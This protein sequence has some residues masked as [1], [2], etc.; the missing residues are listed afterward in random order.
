MREAI[1]GRPC[2]PPSRPTEKRNHFSSANGVCAGG[3]Q[4]SCARSSRDCGP[5][6]AMLCRSSVDSLTQT[7]QPEAL[8]LLAQPDAVVLGAADEAEV[9][10]RR[11][12]RRCRRR[13]SR[14]SRCTS[15]CR[16]P[17]RRRA[18]GCRASSSPA[19]AP[20]R[21]G[22]GSRTS[23]AARGPSPPRCSRQAQYSSTAPRLS[24]DGRQPVAV[25]L[26]EA[27]RQRRGLRVERR[28]PSSASA[29]RRA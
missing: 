17:G 27:P 3:V 16:R 14:R 4:T 11:A 24:Y 22:R 2:G 6:T 29:R 25:V 5:C 8:G 7:R 18:G 12:G 28:S 10:R 1:S 26:G 9:V 15:P 23:A 13:A 20:R 19:A 21:R